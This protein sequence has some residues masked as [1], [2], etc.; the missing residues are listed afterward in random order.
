VQLGELLAL[1]V[2]HGEAAA[3]AARAGRE[4][5]ALRAQVEALK[6]AWTCPICYTRDVDTVLQ[7]CGHT[8]C[9]T[10]ASALPPPG[11]CP[12]DRRALA[13]KLKMYKN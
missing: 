12:F 13:G 8:L 11:A 9:A 7:P 1:R 4:A 10:C 6:G 5:D 3:A 2:A